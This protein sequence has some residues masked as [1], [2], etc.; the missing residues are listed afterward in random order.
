MSIFYGGNYLRGGGWRSS[1]L[2]K[3]ENILKNLY[4]QYRDDKGNVS[5]PRKPFIRWIDSIE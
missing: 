2:L 1:E 3:R 4:I 5:C